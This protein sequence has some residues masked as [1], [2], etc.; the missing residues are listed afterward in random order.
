MRPLA[1]CAI[2]AAECEV[3]SQQGRCRTSRLRALNF[4]AADKSGTDGTDAFPNRSC[5]SHAEHWAVPFWALAPNLR[6]PR[7]NLPGPA[8]E[9][10]NR[11]VHA[12]R[13]TAQLRHRC[14]VRKAR[15][16]FC[17]NTPRRFVARSMWALSLRRFASPCSPPAASG[18][19]R[20]EPAHESRHLVVYVSVTVP[21]H[22]AL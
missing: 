21:T 17:A 13:I 3:R 15:S 4:G 8:I 10:D 16:S 18:T 20:G 11:N 14:A 19:V 6:P 7:C 2:A 12:V 22:I 9:F 1:P 5:E